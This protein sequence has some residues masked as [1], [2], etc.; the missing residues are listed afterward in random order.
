MS[1]NNCSIRVFIE[2]PVGDLTLLSDIRMTGKYELTLFRSDRA[3]IFFPVLNQF[4]QRE[5]K[6]ENER[7]G[8]KVR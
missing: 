2:A 3:A 7:K 5:R 1:E 6:M 4:V 8:D